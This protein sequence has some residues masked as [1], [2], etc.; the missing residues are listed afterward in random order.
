M[1]KDERQ[2]CANHK[3][4]KGLGVFLFGAIWMY[5]TTMFV[6]VWSALPSTIA[7]IGLLLLLF[8]LFKRTKI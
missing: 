1:T 2:E 7:T 8:G 3:I 5:Y 4:I 6:D